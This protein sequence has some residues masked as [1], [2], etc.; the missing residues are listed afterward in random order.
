MFRLVQVSILVV[1]DWSR[2]RVRPK[3]DHSVDAGPV[4]FQSLL[5]WIGRV[6]KLACEPR[7]RVSRCFNP[8][9]RGLVASTRWLV[10]GTAIRRP[11]FNP[12]CRGLVAS[13]PRR[14]RPAESRLRCFN[15]CCRGLVASTAMRRS[16]E[17]GSTHVSILV[18]VDWSRQPQPNDPPLV[19]IERVS[20]LVVVDWSRQ[21]GRRATLSVAP[22]SFNPCCRGLVASTPARMP[23][24]SDSRQ[25]S[26]LVVV[27][28]SRQPSLRCVD[29]RPDQPGFNPC[30]RGLVASTLGRSR[31]D[32][33]A[34]AM[35]QS[36]LSWIGRVNTE[37]PSSQQRLAEVSILVVVDWSRQPLWY[38][39][40]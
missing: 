9:C 20:I 30:C 38:P 13:T 33:I 14:L 15:P 31:S 7:R 5:S 26:I 28:W 19:T 12:C 34:L 23:D 24:A 17:R 1:V 21:P 39:K 36:L 6:N 32:M 3:R 8:C 4:W 40:L 35:F 29:S 10:S 16:F 27:D 11:C 37:P 18:V 2:Q 25:V 22:L